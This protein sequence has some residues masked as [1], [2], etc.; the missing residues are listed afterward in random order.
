MTLPSFREFFFD[1]YRREPFPWQQR[2]AEQ[3]VGRG[4][5]EYPLLDLPTGAG[6]TS[7][8]D[9]ALY[10][11]ACAPELMPRRTVLVVDRR[12]VVDEGATRARNLLRALGTAKDGPAGA[13]AD[14]LR[15]LSG[16]GPNDAPFAVSVMRGGMPR[17][18]DWAR[19][20]EIPL[21]GLSTV[22]QIG[23]RM[24]FRGYGISPRSA[25]IH[26]GLLG[27]DT[28]ILLDE[29]HLA[30]PFAQT[31][32]SARRFRATTDLPDRFAVVRMSAT[33][34][35]V[36]DA[37][38][39]G[40]D[41]EDRRNDVLRARL[42]ASKRA[43][44]LTVK[45]TG[46]D[47]GKKLD[48]VANEAVRQA[49]D[50]QRTGTK[51]VGVVLNRVDGARRARTLLGAQVASILV[52]GRMRPIDRDSTVRELQR[53]AGP[54][55]RDAVADPL[56]VVA[57][58]C[59][60]AGADLDF[61]ALVTECASLDALRQ[62]FG[63]LD[64][65]GQLK[66]TSAVILGRSDIIARDDDPI[67]G[68]AIK[69]TWSWLQAN[70]TAGVVDFGI[71]ALPS[72]GDTGLL[73]PRPNAPVL[74]PA[75]LDAWTQTSPRPDF[76]PDIGIWLHGLER[77]G[78]D[79]QIIFRADLVL[80]AD[81]D[82]DV[83]TAVSRLLAARPS[84]LEALAVPIGAARRWL[85][86]GAVSAIADVM[87]GDTEPDEIE[88]DD[89][90]APVALR[91]RGEDSA[92][93]SPN[94]LRPGDTLILPSLKGGIRD[95]SFDPRC[96][97]PVIDVG[98]LA[99]LRGRAI[100]QLRLGP[101]HLQVWDLSQELIAQAPTPLAGETTSELRERVRAWMR[102]TPESL[103]E[104][105]LATRA[106][107]IAYRS[108]FI[109]SNARVTRTEDSEGA[110]LTVRLSSR[111][112]NGEVAES[113]S[114]DDDSSFIGQDVTLRVHSDDV[115]TVVGRFARSLYVPEQ[116]A[117]DLEL[118]A[119]LHDVGKADERF[120]RWLV[121]GS[122]VAAATLAEPLAKSRFPDASPTDRRIAQQRAGYPLGYRHELLSLAMARDNRDVLAAAFDIDLVLHLVASHHGYA[123]PFAPFDDHPDDLP[124]VLQH[125]EVRL[126]ATTR[127]R[128]GRLGSD[129]PA[130]FHR[131]QEKYGW[132][133]LAWLEA[134]L[135]LA[136][137][138]A[139]RMR[140][141]G[142]AP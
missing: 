58:Q 5:K 119:W 66:T 26:A 24:F 120:Q 15:A 112:L 110:V 11:L 75:H 10:A 77:P 94:E 46:S 70:A 67:Y 27:N 59:L 9:I 133:G 91:W 130:R 138:R 125:G 129:V 96:T 72:C 85:A 37:D 87:A 92:W 61:D 102:S 57:T 123:R 80:P 65:R 89:E 25:S 121:G 101:A 86:D 76:D 42:S 16:A 139:S 41:D 34:G 17:D 131:V 126:D 18:N 54:R 40:L 93:V 137:H 83:Q 52:T 68:E 6:K 100:A 45:V 122:E 33:P 44:L 71:D 64:R 136:D 99:A 69:N 103:S 8:L 2:L 1:V 51:V 23:S 20:P 63:R 50:L 31:L 14:A 73:A 107:W 35:V 105:S 109:N 43:Q 118:A 12:I 116:I 128:L 132:W 60:E 114:E 39:F 79:V 104:N 13:I 88:T 56:V 124:V 95:R 140:G 3:V 81:P 47:E 127:H 108:A 32:D 82:A 29:V 7:A 30:E 142:G 115:R 111:V 113:L 19:S 98:D 84:S 21:I 53:L 117:R 22:D 38:R 106:E 62:R 78:V 28:L 4:W 90:M 134:I 135:R 49:L 74:L 48:A 36:A 97:E 141:E 55:D